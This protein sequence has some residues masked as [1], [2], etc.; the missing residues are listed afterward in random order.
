M[1]AKRPEMKTPAESPGGERLQ[2][3]LAKAGVGSRRACEEMIAAGRVLVNGEPARLGRR[4]NPETDAVTVDG[5]GVGVR[6]DL[7]YYLLNKPAE[8]VSTARDPEGRPTVTGL[9]PAKP[10]VY[11]VGRLDADSEGLILLTNDGDLAY[12]LTH[13]GF[14]VEKEY[15]AQVD[16]VPKAGA[17]RRLRE[18]VQL[19]DGLTAPAKVAALGPGTLRITVHEGRKR[20]VR[21]MGEAVGHPVRRLVRTRIG[22]LRI[23]SLR[24]GQWRRLAPEE[25]R[26]LE[27]AARGS[28]SRSLAAR[29]PRCSPS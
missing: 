10:R 23:G 15:I 11:P 14:E 5:V 9:V 22:P 20:Q 25:V 4:I 27:R 17:I 7:V 12:R 24:P 19:E 16:G 18:G 26:A 13:P 28:G 2:K 6:D 8:V 29:G 3:V 21:R 1:P